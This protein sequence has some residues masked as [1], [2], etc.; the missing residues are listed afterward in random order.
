MRTLLKSGSYSVVGRA[1]GI[2]N[3]KIQAVVYHV[4]VLAA[5]FAAEQ[6]RR[7]VRLVVNEILP[8]SAFEFC[9]E[10]LSVQQQQRKRGNFLHF[11]P[12]THSVPAMNHEAKA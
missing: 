10:K 6:N 2:P 9:G 7:H 8:P 11:R 3:V 4:N 5:A 12:L 1:V